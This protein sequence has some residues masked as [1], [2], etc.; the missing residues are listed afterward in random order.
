[1]LTAG[2]PDSDEHTLLVF[3]LVAGENGFE[4]GGKPVNE[5]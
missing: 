3:A 1:M 4:H 5:F 2:A